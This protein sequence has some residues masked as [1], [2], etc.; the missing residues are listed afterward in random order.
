MSRRRE[1]Q[2]QNSIRRGRSHPKEKVRAWKWKYEGCCTEITASPL[3]DEEKP[4]VKF[5]SGKAVEEIKAHV[6]MYRMKFC[7]NLMGKRCEVLL[8]GEIRSVLKACRVSF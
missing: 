2:R 4:E 8:D 1:I 6:K 5:C 7:T 3:S